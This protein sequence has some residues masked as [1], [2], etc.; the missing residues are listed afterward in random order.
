[1][2]GMPVPLIVFN[3]LSWPVTGIV[4]ILHPVIVATS[5]SGDRQPVQQIPS[6]EVTYSPTR[7]IMQL[8]VPPLG[9]RRFWLHMVDPEPGAPAGDGPPAAAA[10]EARGG[11]TLTNGLLRVVIDPRSGALASLVVAG[12][13][14]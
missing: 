14:R 12:E 1:M 11:A 13:G 2:L 5:A 3:P 7:S 8:P 4:S 10:T 9:Y 6:G